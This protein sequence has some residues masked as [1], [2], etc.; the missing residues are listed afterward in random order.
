MERQL[1]SFGKTVVLAESTSE[2]SEYQ[3]ST[4]RQMLLAT[5][6]QEYAR[7]MGTDWSCVVETNPDGSAK[8][9]PNG[10]RVVESLLL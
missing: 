4:W 9:V 5:L 1:R 10:L 6:R 2:S 3:R 8:Y 7:M